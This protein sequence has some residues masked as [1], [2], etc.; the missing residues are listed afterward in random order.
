MRSASAQVAWAHPKFGSLLATCGYDMKAALPTRC[1]RGLSGN[2]AV[3]F[4]K[5]LVVQRHRCAVGFPLERH[6]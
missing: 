1:Q 4:F 5:Q 2:H 6:T 3:S